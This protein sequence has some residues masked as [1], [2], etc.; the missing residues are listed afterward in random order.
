MLYVDKSATKP[1]WAH[2]Y[3]RDEGA[4]AFWDDDSPPTHKD[5]PL[6]NRNQDSAALEDI[7]A[8]DDYFRA[9][10]GTG[11][12]VSAGG[13]NIIFADSNTHFRGQ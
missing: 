10:P 8:W 13:V 3:N 6:Y 9:R 1:L 4:R 11:R 5:S 7:A 2:E 12:R